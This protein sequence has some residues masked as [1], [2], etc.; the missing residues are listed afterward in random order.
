M[1]IFSLERGR[2]DP[3]FARALFSNLC[4]QYYQT[5]TFQNTTEKTFNSSE[6]YKGF[7]IN[8][9]NNENKNNEYVEKK[10]KLLDEN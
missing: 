9:N 1:H 7:L 2:W 6:N 4:R 3:R 10:L 5:K 8:N